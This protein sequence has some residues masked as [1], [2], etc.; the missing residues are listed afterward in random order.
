MGRLI[1]EI[2]RNEPTIKLYADVGSFELVHKT[3]T[4]HPIVGWDRRLRHRGESSNFEQAFQSSFNAIENLS[5]NFV[6]RY[7]IFLRR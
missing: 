6:G 5:W 2:L 7:V 1:H 3:K 4:K